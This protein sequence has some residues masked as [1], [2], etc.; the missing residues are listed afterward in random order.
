MDQKMFFIFLLIIL[1]IYIY[2][3]GIIDALLN[4]IPLPVYQ[5]YNEIQG[6][7]RCNNDALCGILE[8]KETTAANTFYLVAGEYSFGHGLEYFFTK[9]GKLICDF[10]W[11]IDMRDDYKGPPSSCPKYDKCKK[12]IG[13]ISDI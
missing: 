12:I 5:K 3:Y 7:F 11:N 13:N 4:G 6:N 2:S 10:S 1:V 8:C 9:D